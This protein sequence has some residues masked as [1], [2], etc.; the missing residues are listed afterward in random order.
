MTAY[1][2]AG[3]HLEEHD[4]LADYGEAYQRYRQRVRMLVPIP[5]HFRTPFTY[6]HVT[7][8]GARR[9]KE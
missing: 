7:T 4:L 3:I 8:S 9:G 5:R 2:F 6:N 1:I